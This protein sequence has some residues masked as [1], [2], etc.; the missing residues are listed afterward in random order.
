[1]IYILKKI[2]AQM[3]QV[4]K[5]NKIILK[6]NLHK[7]YGNKSF[8]NNNYINYNKLIYKWLNNFILK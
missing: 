1:M 6:T 2:K 8:Y 3:V 4:E 5:K 7:K